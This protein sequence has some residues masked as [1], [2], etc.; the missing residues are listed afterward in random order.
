MGEPPKATSRILTVPNLFS[1]ARILSIPFVVRAILEP[2]TSFAGLIA[3]GVVLSTDWVDGT[4][5]RATGQISEVGKVLDPVADRLAIAAGLIALVAVGAFPTWAAAL[6]LGR[7]AFLLVAGAVILARHRLRIDV[8]RVG[9][10]AT[11]SL[12]LAIG[13]LSWAGLDGP[14]ADGFAVIGWT[15]LAVGLVEYYAAAFLYFTDL[16][17]ALRG[18]R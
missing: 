1:A 18:V 10:I 5:A 17:R 14:L 12:M 3:L 2:D 11:V 4:I 8:R 6:I 13:G 9:K 15:C 7:D 16:R